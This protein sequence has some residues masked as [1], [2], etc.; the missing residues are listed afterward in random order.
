FVVTGGSP[1]TTGGSGP[2]TINGSSAALPFGLDPKT[3]P[4]LGSYGH[5]NGTAE[6]TSGWYRLPARDA[7]P[8][9]VIT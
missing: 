7:S 8:L 1:G 5:D 6:L 3:T 4:V 9:L 2:K